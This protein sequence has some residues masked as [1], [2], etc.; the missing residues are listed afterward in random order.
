MEVFFAKPNGEPFFKHVPWSQNSCLK[1]L[2]F[3]NVE[4]DYQKSY[5]LS[6]QKTV[7]V[8]FSSKFHPW[9]YFLQNNMGNHFLNMFH[10]TKIVV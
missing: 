8:I 7:Y 2:F 6:V 10:G 4:I 9:Q 1:L 5:I 3:R